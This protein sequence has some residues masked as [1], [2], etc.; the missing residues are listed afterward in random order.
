[1]V[2]TRRF[3]VVLALMAWQGGFMFY[4]AVTVPVTR[5]KLEGRPERSIITQK[6]TQWMNLIGTAAILAMYAD[7]WA[8][9]LKSRRWRWIVW[10]G[11]ALPHPLLLWLHLKLSDQMAAPGFHTSNL[12]GFSHWHR[13][14]LMVNTLQWAAGMAFVVLS[15]RAWREEDRDPRSPASGSIP[16]A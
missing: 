8:S 14:Y 6:V 3:L 2:M 15:L 16:A 5:A 10:L 13:A 4:G 11:M 7:C 1:M 12:A 9:P